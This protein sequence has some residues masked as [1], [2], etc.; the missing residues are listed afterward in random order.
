M[1]GV[2]GQPARRLNG[3]CAAF[4]N[5][6]P[7]SNFKFPSLCVPASL[8]HRRTATAWNA[9][10][11]RR[12]RCSDKPRASGMNVAPRNR[13][14]FADGPARAKTIVTRNATP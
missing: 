9:T 12:Q 3:I 6:R 5:A 8:N 4:V 10:F 11:A 7:P 1:A 13:G 14:D 2:Y